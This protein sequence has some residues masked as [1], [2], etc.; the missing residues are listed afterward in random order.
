MSRQLSH[1]PPAENT[2]GETTSTD[3]V[4]QAL[5]LLREGGGRSTTARRVLLM[6][7]FTG[8][9]H[10]TA[11]ELASEVRALAPDVAL[12]TVYRNLD[13]LERVGLVV[14]AHLGHGPAVYHLAS[15]GHPHLVCESCGAVVEAPENLFA[16]LARGARNRYGFEVDPRHFAI[17]GRCARCVAIPPMPEDGGESP[18]A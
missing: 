4:E 11:E 3:R 2:T 10:R 9:A 1:K 13:E 14:H 5:E 6:C 8:G 7:L 15:E 17:L 12:S 16:A 18:K